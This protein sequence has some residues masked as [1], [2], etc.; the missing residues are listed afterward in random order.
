MNELVTNAFLAPIQNPRRKLIL[1]ALALKAGRSTKLKINPTE[2]APIVGLD[3]GSG[4]EKLAL[5]ISAMSGQYLDMQ[6]ICD[7]TV[8]LVG[9]N[10]ERLYQMDTFQG[11]A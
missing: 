7:G 1:V 3:D 8:P 4:A 5:H 9:V 6:M 11:V 2:L 10:L